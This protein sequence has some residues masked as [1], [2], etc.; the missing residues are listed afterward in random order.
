MELLVSHV[1]LGSM[2][3]AG[4]I[5]VG[6]W[7]NARWPEKVSIVGS[8]DANL[9]KELLA[10]LYRL[11]LRMAAD[12]G[13]HHA[14]VGEVDREL[15][16][17]PPHTAPAIATLVTRLMQANEE[18]QAKL[19]SAESKLEEL[20]QKMA[21]HATEARTD[22]LT[23]LANRRVFEEETVKRL[24]EFHATDHPFSIVIL[25]ID[26][27]KPINDAHGHLQG[28]EILR[29]VAVALLENVGGRDI[30]TRYGGEEFAILMPGVSIEHACRCA[31]NLRETIAKTRFRCGDKGLD[32]TVSAGVAEV[33]A[34][35]DIVMLVHRA[36]QAMYA[37]KHAGRNCVFWHDGITSH[38]LN[39]ERARN[40]EPAGDSVERDEPARS[41]E[42]IVACKSRETTAV[43]ATNPLSAEPSVIL[44]QEDL[45]DAAGIDLESLGNLNNKTMFC[46]HVHRRISEWNRGGMSF[47]TIL[48]SID[49]YRQLRSDYG[50]Q[51]TELAL[52]VIAQ[53]IRSSLRGMDLVARYDD[54]TFG[55]LLP[56]ASLRNAICIGER[57][58]KD[59]RNT[60]IAIEG[61]TV[62]FTI[63]LGIVEVSEGD[64]MASL[65]ER[66]AAQLAQASLR[67]G[68]RTGFAAKAF[69][70]S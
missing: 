22:A 11:S 26:H 20:T 51:A 40:Q 47:S 53:T 36:D 31:E 49:N 27:F 28:D 34:S 19:T 7:L 42:P 48:L 41:P 29:D 68:N 15:A 63:S 52:G 8:D 69:A 2:F 65:L 21:Y 43:P 6:W 23:G 24:S 37:A 54:E 17:G 33:Q 5:W 3:A 4:G 70:V 39:Q 14:R 50:M 38:P 58:R 61:K 44:S 32:V 12:V 66:A 62:R 30:V 13:E 60:G 9:A 64:V 1:L 59:V 55:L 25:D 16:A 45:L 10:S 18:V 46:Q 35:E 57:L 67:G 56:D